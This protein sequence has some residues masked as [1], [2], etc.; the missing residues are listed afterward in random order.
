MNT[1]LRELWRGLGPTEDEVRDQ[2]RARGD[3]VPGPEG[4]RV[5]TFQLQ[6]QRQAE[7]LDQ[8]LDQLVEKYEVEIYP[9][10]I[11]EVS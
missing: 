11:P 1:L 4:L 6:R 5:V 2:I 8:Y 3:D 10:R 7:R 9:D